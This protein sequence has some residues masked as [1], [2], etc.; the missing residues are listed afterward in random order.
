MGR[1]KIKDKV[2][3]EVLLASRR[4]CAF[5]FGLNGDFSEKKG[6]LAHIDRNNSNSEFQNLAFL[7][8]NH[9]DQ[10]DSKTSQSKGLTPAELK[11]YR[12]KLYISLEKSVSDRKTPKYM[13][14]G[15]SSF[16]YP[17]VDNICSWQVKESQVLLGEKNPDRSGYYPILV[18]LEVLQKDTGVLSS[19]ARDELITWSLSSENFDHQTSWFKHSA[20]HQDPADPPIYD[21]RHTAEVG[22]ALSI[23]GRSREQLRRIVENVLSKQGQGCA[24]GA[25]KSTGGSAKEDPLSTVVC[26]ELLVRTKEG[27]TTDLLSKPILEGIEKAMSYL[28][29][30]KLARGWK[31]ENLTEPFWEVWGAAIVGFRLRHWLPT[32]LGKYT[33]DCLEKELEQTDALL[34]VSLVQRVRLLVRYLCALVVLNS[35]HQLLSTWLKETFHLWKAMDHSYRDISTELHMAFLKPWILKGIA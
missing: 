5:C 7:C 8:F 31:Y 25:W 10:Y 17:F 14:V 30:S 34:G 27:V 2:V 16:P 21:I 12:D 24:E 28:E 18:G 1:K 35:Q 32:N 19:D 11:S 15:D 9:H 4:R 23:D 33:S 26:T 6:Q 13:A 3:A 20:G 22:I 29:K